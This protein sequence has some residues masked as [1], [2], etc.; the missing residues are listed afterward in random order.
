MKSI[1]NALEKFLLPIATKM[2]KQKHLQSVKDGMIAIVPIIIVGSFCLVPTG[3]GNLIGGGVLE[4]VTKYSAI[5]TFPTYFTSNIM[6]LFS[7]FFI[8]DSL[9]KRYGMKSTLI[10]MTSVLVHLMLCVTI[11]ETGWSVAYLGAEGLFVSIIV[12]LVVPEVTRLMKKYN[13][14]IKMPDSVPPMVADS[15]SNLLP[16]IV[17]VV[18]ATA[19][20][21]LC[22]EFAGVSFP[23]LIIQFLA[24][25]ISGMDSLG[26]V[27]IIV[28]LT[29]ILWFF[30]L[31][32]AA[33]TSSVW[34][35]FAIANGAANAA[36]VA[37][38][39]DPQYVFTFG[40]Y[41]GFLQVSGSGITFLLV[42]MMCF[43]KAKSLRSIGRIS[44]VPSIFGIN[45]PVIFGAPIIMNPYLFIPFVFGPCV[46]A[47]ICYL[48][49]D[50]GFVGLPL[51]EAPG[52]LPPGF[53]AFLLTLDWKAAAMCIGCVILMGIFYYPFFKAMEADELKK[54]KEV[55]ALETAQ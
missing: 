40:F 50:L 45:E 7:A 51:W 20:T 26:A 46:V 33:I 27:L 39:T 25:A 3:I 8:A 22:Q 35:A 23:A 30:G 34:A 17:D 49:M 41:Y 16:L 32:G 28:F 48:A 11:T 18:L 12:G 9:A 38:G 2:E 52:F 29:Q 44:I 43:S 31:H 5:F 10:G 4:F 54:E 21:M 53:Q 55:E 47:A 37:A 15:F 1:Q 36:A 13:L 24:P 42:L 19:V 14:V 6:S